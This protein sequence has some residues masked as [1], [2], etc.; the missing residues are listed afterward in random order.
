MSYRFSS[1][2]LLLKHSV[3]PSIFFLVQFFS[4]L[5]KELCWRVTWLGFRGLEKTN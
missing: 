1:K 3:S 2:K 5:K 4:F